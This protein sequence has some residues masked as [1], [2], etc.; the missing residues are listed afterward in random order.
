MN[1][2]SFKICIVSLEAFCFVMSLKIDEKTSLKDVEACFRQRIQ[3]IKNE[4]A[5]FS[6]T[7]RTFHFTKVCL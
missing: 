4:I 6:F 7:I 5:T 3:K 2:K 1:F